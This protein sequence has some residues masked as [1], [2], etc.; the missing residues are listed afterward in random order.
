MYFIANKL[1]Q[2][3]NKHQLQSIDFIPTS[4][5]LHGIIRS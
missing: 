5:K 4:S 1:S 2:E 3:L